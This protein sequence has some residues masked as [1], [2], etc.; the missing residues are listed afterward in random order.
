MLTPYVPSPPE[1]GDEETTAAR[2]L[3]DLVFDIAAGTRFN[4]EVKKHIDGWLPSVTAD[5]ALPRFPEGASVTLATHNRPAETYELAP[6]ERVQIEL[7]PR[8]LGDITPFLQVT[9]RR[10]VKGDVI[11][12]SAVICSRLQGAPDERFREILARQIDTP[13][14]F[15]RLLALLIGFAARS[16]T[17]GA[18][19]GDSTWRW[20]PGNGDGVLELLARALSE[21]PEAID[22]LE[23]IVERLRESPT[24]R[25]VLPRGWDDVWLPALEARRA[26]VGDA[27]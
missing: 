5:T 18:T 14:K 4:T 3:E 23:S 24:G 2:A 10:T 6:G 19:A 8:E 7:L 15:M 17:E 21:R 1:E 20:A 26:M 9:A 12:R 13:E 11:E 22:H 25:A 16:G 27:P